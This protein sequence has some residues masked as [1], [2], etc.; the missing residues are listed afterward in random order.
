MSDFDAALE[1]LVSD[2][3][4][5]SALADD[6]AAALAGYRLTS[7]E[8]ELLRSTIDSGVGGQRQVE[9]RTSKASLFGLLSPLAGLGGFGDA[10]HGGIGS[11]AGQGGSGIASAAPPSGSG[12]GSGIASAAPPSG[13]G[14][15]SGVG[16]AAEPGWYGTGAAA[17][18]DSAGMG[19]PHD[20]GFGGADST[21]VPPV[22][23]TSEAGHGAAAPYHTRVDANG[24]GRWDPFTVVD[25]GP[26]GVDIVVDR[27]RDG[28]AEFVGRDANRDGLIDE[29]WTDE[30]HDGR[31]ETHWVDDNGDG[32]LDRRVSDAPARPTAAPNEPTS[33]VQ[34]PEERD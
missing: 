14:V 17:H 21:V 26:E 15:G 30:N 27:D 8:L 19:A 29:A 4:F 2:P 3:A 10:A 25:R 7:D 33:L 28:F 31:L 34:H 20:Q 11:A 32:W 6:P 5:R 18:A 1:R 24:D 9:Q 16:S 12:G 22:G 23:Q 13:S